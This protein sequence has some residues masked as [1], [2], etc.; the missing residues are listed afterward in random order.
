MSLSICNHELPDCERSLDTYAL[1]YCI[2]L[3]ALPVDSI[4]IVSIHGIKSRA[5]GRGYLSGCNSGSFHH[6]MAEQC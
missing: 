1:R 6:L 2:N 5:E 4:A 3:V